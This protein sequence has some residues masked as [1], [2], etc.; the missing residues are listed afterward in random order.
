M[1]LLR[2]HESPEQVRADISS[3]YFACYDIMRLHSK[4]GNMT[5]VQKNMRSY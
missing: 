4:I 2:A 3:E 5:P 1:C